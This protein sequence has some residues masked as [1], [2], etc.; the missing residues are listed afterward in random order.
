MSISMT[1]DKK[2]QSF[3]HQQA[4][5]MNKPVFF[6]LLLCEEKRLYK[7]K[8]KNMIFL[9]SFINDGE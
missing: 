2:V 7:R 1:I 8:K 5:T 3:M 6:S 4:Q 9:Y